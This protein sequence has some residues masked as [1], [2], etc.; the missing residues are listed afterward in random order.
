MGKK[1]GLVTI[2]ICSERQFFWHVFYVTVNEVGFFV[3]VCFV[4]FFLAKFLV[5]VAESGWVALLVSMSCSWCLSSSC[6]DQDNYYL[7]WC[8]SHSIWFWIQIRFLH[9]KSDSKLNASLQSLRTIALQAEH[10]IYFLS[11]ILLCTCWQR[12]SFHLPTYLA[13]EFFHQHCCQSPHTPV[14][15][16]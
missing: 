15:A 4:G 6:V 9:M 2:N 10:L 5:I 1:S 3:F 14:L 11:V 16:R 7:V 12:C 13:Q 8:Y